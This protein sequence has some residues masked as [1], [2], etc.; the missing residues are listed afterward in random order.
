MHWVVT[1][2]HPNC[3]RMAETNLARQE[4]TYYGPKILERKIVRGRQQLV[5]QPLFPCYMFVQIVD[6]WKALKSTYGVADLIGHVR[7]NVI[8]DLK[9]REQ[10]GYI[11]LPKARQFDV[12][13]QVMIKTGPFAGQQALVERMPSKDRQK[14][15]LAL[16]ANKISVLVNENELEAA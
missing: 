1:R 5:E 13:D 6:R 3:D 14:I 16:L 12:G 7:D 11:Q 8:D 9:R 4:F 15:L 2:I 10:N